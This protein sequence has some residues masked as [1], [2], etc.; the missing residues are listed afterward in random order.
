VLIT[1]HVSQPY[2][3][4]PSLLQEQA[5]VAPERLDAFAGRVEV[6]EQPAAPKAAVAPQPSIPP[7]AAPSGVAGRLAGYAANIGLSLVGGLVGGLALGVGVGAILGPSALVGLA[8]LGGVGGAVFGTVGGSIASGLAAHHTGTPFQPARALEV[9][10]A[11]GAGGTVVA[12]GL[13]LLALRG[14]T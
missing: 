8:R 10:A 13:V 5:S 2:A 6:G 11:A 12:L 9:G 3:P 14:L 1:P 7:R 4:Q